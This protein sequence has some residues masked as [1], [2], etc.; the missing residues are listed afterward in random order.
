LNNHSRE[1]FFKYYTAKAAKAVLGD[2]KLKWSSPILF[3]DPFDNQIELLINPDQ[4][5]MAKQSLNNFM[6][7]IKSDLPL[8]GF[9]P[10]M[11]Q[12]IMVIRQAIKA[13][14]VIEDSQL[15][16]A[17]LEGARK[18][19]EKMPELNRDIKKLLSDVSIFCLTET[20]ENKLMWSHYADKYQGVVIRFKA[21]I[22]NSPFTV[23]QPVTYVE[24]L[25]QFDA[26]DFLNLESMPTKSIKYITLTKGIEWSYEKEWRIVS[27]MRNPENTFE[28]ISFNPKELTALYLGCKISQ[29]DKSDLIDLCRLNFPHA[30]IYSSFLEPR[31]LSVRFS[32]LDG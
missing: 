21:N 20:N 1:S 6:S 22:Y 5:L 24:S 13:G 10:L 7:L 23:A 2:I 9:T 16:E 19:S 18:A 32:L 15:I 3:N 12:G 4:D 28:L 8:D 17:S 14:Y 29:E 11:Q 26:N 27:G 30:E 25:P 31:D